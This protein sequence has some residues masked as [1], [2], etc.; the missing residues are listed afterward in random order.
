MTNHRPPA[1][2]PKAPTQD[3]VQ[4]LYDALAPGAEHAKSARELCLDL[5][6]DPTESNC[7]LIRLWKEH[8]PDF[9]LIIC[10]GQAGYWRY[11]QWGDDAE[12]TAM[13]N[14][15]VATMMERQRQRRALIQAQLQQGS[16]F[17]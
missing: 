5:G 9:G 8:G 12:M 7:R 15:Q 6:M 11:A 1:Q 16:L 14:A 13:E 4:R 2:P 17:D 10:S 3:E